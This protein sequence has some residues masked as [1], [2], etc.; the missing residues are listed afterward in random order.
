MFA[1]AH[2]GFDAQAFLLLSAGGHDASYAVEQT[3]VVGEAGKFRVVIIRPGSQSLRCSLLVA[4]TRKE[5]ERNGIA[6][7]AQNLQ[8]FQ[9]VHLGHLEIA[10]DAVELLLFE[11]SQCLRCRF[12]SFDL[13]VLI[14]AC[15][16]QANKLRLICF[17]FYVKY[18]N[19][20][21]PLS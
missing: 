14:Q 15:Q 12:G 2:R 18:T 10:E 17:V 21:A 6:L 9:S 5:N 20:V 1:L 7:P 16:P 8:K 13:E 19:H 3:L 11:H 4:L